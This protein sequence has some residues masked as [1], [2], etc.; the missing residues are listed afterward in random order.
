MPLEASTLEEHQARYKTGQFTWPDLTSDKYCTGCR[1]YLRAPRDKEKGRCDLV[2]RRHGFTGAT[3]TGAD[4][5]ACSQFKD[6]THE[7]TPEYPDDP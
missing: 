3:F 1:L 5:I 7:D 4:A 2:L 6:G